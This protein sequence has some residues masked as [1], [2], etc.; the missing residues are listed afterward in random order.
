[1]RGTGRTQTCLEDSQK[2]YYYTESDKGHSGLLQANIMVK[3]RKSREIDKK[4]IIVDQILWELV[5]KFV[6]Y[7]LRQ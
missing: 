1:M 3:R 6:F 4:D 7:F 2:S 5:S